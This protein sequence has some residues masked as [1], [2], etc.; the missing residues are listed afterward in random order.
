MKIFAEH[1]FDIGEM[2]VSPLKGLKT[3]WEKEKMLVTNIFSFP[4]M[5]SICRRFKVG[6]TRG[7]LHKKLT[8]LEKKLFEN[9]LEKMREYC[10]S[11]TSFS[12]SFIS[13]P[14]DN[15]L[16]VTKFKAFADDK[17]NVAKMMIS[18]YDRVENTVG[19]GEN[20][21]CQHFLLFPQCFPKPSSFGLL[22]VRLNC[23]L[24]LLWIW[25]SLKFVVW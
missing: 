21:G 17:F 25:T 7:L 23:C 8:I 6:K 16:N 24:R 2:V 5:F 11:A 18:P 14:H 10:Y 3:L 4:A 20:A 19:K 22:R 1:K 15:I 9:N 12:H 13:L